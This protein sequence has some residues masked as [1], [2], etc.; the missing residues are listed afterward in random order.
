MVNKS[1]LFGIIGFLLGGLL[2]SGAY[3]ISNNNNQNSTMM[4]NYSRSDTDMI[5]MNAETNAKLMNLKG[6]DFD[7]AFLHEMIMHHQ[8]AIDMARLIET[9]AKHDEIKQLGKDIITAQTK[10]IQMMKAWQKAWMYD[11]Y[12]N[13]PGMM[14]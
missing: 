12:D 6:D 8:G 5:Q 4:G 11:Q 13:M 3:T 7:E 1:L 14:H 10:E 9:N 2:V